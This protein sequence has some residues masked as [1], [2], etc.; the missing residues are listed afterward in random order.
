[1]LVTAISNG[2]TQ[3]LGV[4]QMVSGTGENQAAAV[5]QLLQEWNLLDKVA[6][7]GFDTTSCN[8]V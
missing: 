3:F 8:T 5:Y 1:M 4:P 2:K 6:G 7:M